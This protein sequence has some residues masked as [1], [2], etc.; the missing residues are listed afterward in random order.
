MLF[1][2]VGAGGIQ[3][4]AATAVA[5]GTT[6]I[7]VNTALGGNPPDLKGNGGSGGSGGGGGVWGSSA[8]SGGTGAG[9]STYPFGITALL[10]HSAGGGGG[11]SGDEEDGDYY[12]AGDGGTNGGNGKK[13]SGT[14]DK[15]GVGGVYGGGDGLRC[16]YSAPTGNEPKQIMKAKFYGGGG[17]GASREYASTGIHVGTTIGGVG[18]QG[19]AYLL[20]EGSAASA[21]EFKIVKQPTT[22]G[23]YSFDVTAIGNGLTYQ[24]EMRSPTGTSWYTNMPTGWTGATTSTLVAHSSYGRNGYFLRCKITDMYGSVLYTNEVTINHG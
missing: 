1:R 23:R 15:A 20:V 18:Y 17:G 4:S 21:Y 19:V 2:S 24:W 22:A 9:V 12:K 13:G 10:A 11:A 14:D 3:A 8:M 6:S 5:G 16:A 7:G